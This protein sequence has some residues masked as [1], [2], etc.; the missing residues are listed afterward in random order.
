MIVIDYFTKWV[1]AELLTQITKI[2]MEYFIQKSIIYRFDLPHTIITNNG[3]QFD[4]QN[5]KKF[6]VKFHITHKPTSVSHPQSNGEVEV[7]NQT[8]LH[9]LKIRL[10]EVKSL[11]V[12]E[13]YPI[14]WAY[15]TT[16]RIPMGESPF[17][18]AME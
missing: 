12:E 15:R 5:F 1:E 11:W 7:T 13:L 8:I 3:R 2:K 16:P 17:I 14:L 6:Y 10:N 4:N 9:E 18:L